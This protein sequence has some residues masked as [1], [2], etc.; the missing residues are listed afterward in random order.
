VSIV[1]GII[2]LAAVF[3]CSADGP[4]AA[5]QWWMLGRAGTRLGQSAVT[6]LKAA[7]QRRQQTGPCPCVVERREQARRAYLAF[8]PLRN[9]TDHEE[10]RPS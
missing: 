6:R 5:R 8:D 9:A 10:Y 7:G 1:S 2:F 3:G 4:V